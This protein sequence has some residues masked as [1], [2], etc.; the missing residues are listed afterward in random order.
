MCVC[1]RKLLDGWMDTPSILR[2]WG[3]SIYSSHLICFNSFD[4]NLAMVS[5]DFKLVSSVS[6][7]CWVNRYTIMNGY[8]PDNPGHFETFKT[9][10]LVCVLMQVVVDRYVACQCRK[11]VSCPAVCCLSFL[12]SFWSFFCGR[13][14]FYTQPF[15]SRIFYP[16]PLYVCVFWGSTPFFYLIDT[17]IERFSIVF[18]YFFFVFFS[19]V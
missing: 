13:S 18:Q 5:S 12:F 14:I 6:F 17:P 15:L 4:E 2:K 11:G 9:F 3:K 1:E 16:I 19:P 8:L 10:F 7:L